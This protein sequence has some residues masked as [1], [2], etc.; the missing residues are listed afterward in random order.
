M[1]PTH[2]G[3]Q[4]EDICCHRQSL[5]VQMPGVHEEY[6]PPQVPAL[7]GT[8]Q[9]IDPMSRD[10]GDYVVCTDARGT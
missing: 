2:Y 3:V 1:P 8:H 4:Q 9:Q 5:R 7:T 6:T 10:S